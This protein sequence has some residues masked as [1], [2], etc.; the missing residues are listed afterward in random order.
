MNENGALEG[1][2]GLREAQGQVRVL[3]VDAE[4][5]RAAIEYR[6]RLGM[7]HSGGVVQGGFIAGW[8]DSAMSHAAMALSAREMS[9]MTLELKV[10]Y[11]QP[12]GPGL[13][14][15]EGWVE[16]YGR[17]T[18]FLE[19]RLLNTAGDVLAK[20]SAT[21][22]LVPRTR[23]EARAAEAAAAADEGLP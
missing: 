13:V 21:A 15:A 7:C 16:R 23:V 20:A 6:A 10:S 8:L 9:P 12:V 5:G 18:A 17:S 4:A 14:I 11:F 22:R 1:E 19:S 3:S 2:E